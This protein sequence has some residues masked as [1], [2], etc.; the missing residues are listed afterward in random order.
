MVNG[1]A[2]EKKLSPHE[3]VEGFKRLRE[4][5]HQI[6][7]KISEFET[8]KGEHRYIYTFFT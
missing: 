2:K 4:E 3:I 8:E 6:L 7:R 5:Q 1:S